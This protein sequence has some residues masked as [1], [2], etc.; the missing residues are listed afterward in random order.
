MISDQ[1]IQLT[2]GIIQHIYFSQWFRAPREGAE[3]SQKLEN[4]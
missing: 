4:I 3:L 1:K 2:A